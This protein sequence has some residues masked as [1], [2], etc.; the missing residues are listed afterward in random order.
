MKE[1]KFVMTITN[2]FSSTGR[3]IAQKLS[4]L[5]EVPCYNEYIIRE[6]AKTLGL[7]EDVVESTE[8]RS[9]RQVADAFFPTLFQSHGSRTND[10]QDRIFETQNRIIRAL[11]EKE[12]CIIVG[13][14]ADF[15]LEEHPNAVHV[16]IYAPYADRVK[17]CMSWKQ[18]DEESARRMIA[19]QDENRIADHIN[20]TGFSPDDKG[21]KDLLV[22]ASLL[23]T[24]G[25]AQLLAELVRRRFDLP[26]EEP[27]PHRL[28]RQH[29]W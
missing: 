3:V 12:S 15:V 19:Q 18:V 28:P 7:P 13:R 9:K 26:Q 24:D 25:T 5:L 8:E 10:T 20:Y 6:T 14:C 16:Y 29:R 22:N 2:Q 21:H 23:G 11:A 27:R 17:H 4:R 1:N